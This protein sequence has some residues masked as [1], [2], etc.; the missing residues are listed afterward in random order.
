MKTKLI[1]FI[2]LIFNICLKSQTISLKLDCRSIKI[3]G[4]TLYFNYK[5]Q[6]N[7][8]KK[9]VLYDVNVLDFESEYIYTHKKQIHE[10]SKGIT[11]MP[12]ITILVFNKKNQL[13]NNILKSIHYSIHDNIVFKKSNKP[14]IVKSN[15]SLEFKEKIYIGNIGYNGKLDKGQ[16]K[17]QL[18]Y[19]STDYYKNS[20]KR[21]KKNYSKFKDC[22]L[23]VGDVYSNTCFVYNKND[24]I[25]KA[26]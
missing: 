24:I 7:L 3:I 4:D 17:I 12:R 23:F 8:S 6:N 20:F 13:P 5:F 15:D 26:Q 22:E 18:Q 14:V 2:I 21:K 16:Y 9:Y 11:P 19:M 25:I 1:I 10:M